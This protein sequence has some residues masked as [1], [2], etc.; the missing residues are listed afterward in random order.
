LDDPIVKASVESYRTVVG[1]EPVYNGVPG[2]T[3]GTFLHLAGIPIVTT[4]A[5]DR[6]VPHQINEY[7]DLAELVEASRIYAETALIFLN[8]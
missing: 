5:G 6:H 4:G 2:A 3:D 7:I 8:D 1:K